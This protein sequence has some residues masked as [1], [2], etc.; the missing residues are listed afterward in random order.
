MLE[1]LS[2]LAVAIIHTFT[3]VWYPEKGEYINP[4]TEEQ[5]SER[6]TMIAEVNAA[7]AYGEK[8]KNATP[9]RPKDDLALLTAIQRGESAFEYRVHAGEKSHIGTADAGRARCL[10]QIHHVKAWWS[11]DEWRTLAGTSREATRRCA[12]AILRILQYHSNR[13]RLRGKLP[14]KKRWQKPL[15]LREFRSLIR[16]YGSG[17]C[18]GL[19]TKTTGKKAI[20]CLRIRHKLDRGV[21]PVQNSKKTRTISYQVRE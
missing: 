10:G 4:E 7:T 18:D 12:E 20:M 8:G 15:R 19:P 11:K 17:Q 5:R 2:A 16:W 6:L 9:W 3:P 1:T 21:V 14:A 13:C